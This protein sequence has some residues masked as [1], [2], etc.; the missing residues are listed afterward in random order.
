MD[1]LHKEESPGL[2]L[3]DYLAV[4]QQRLPIAAGVFLLVVLLTALFAWTRT[5]RYAATSRLLVESGGVNLTAI[6]GAYDP[7]RASLTQRDIIQTQVQLIKS[8]PVMEDVLQ[9]GFLAQSKDFRE[10]KD[11]VRRLAELSGDVGRQFPP[12]PAA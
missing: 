11:P 3:W 5:P 4:V 10:S 1:E 9:Q 12:A 7:T 6:Q 8:T 2:H